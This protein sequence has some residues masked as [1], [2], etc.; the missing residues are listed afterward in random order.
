MKT[1]PET[2]AN[3]EQSARSDVRRSFFRRLGPGLLTGVADD[4]PSGI[5]TYS[6][7]GSQFGYNVLWSAIV[8]IPLMV[9]IQMASAHIGR[10]T[11]KGIL[12]EVRLQHSKRTAV[13][14]AAMIVLANVINVGADLAAMGDATS[15]LIKGPNYGYALLFAVVTLFLQIRMK[16]SAYA[17]YLKWLALALFA[18]IANIFVVHTDW[19]TALQAIVWPAITPSKE[20]AT[21]LVAVLGTTISPY[22]FVWQSALEVEEIEAREGDKPIK[23]ASSQYKRQETR[24]VA[25]TWVGMLASNVI[26]VCIM[27]TAAAAF[28]VHG[29]HNIESTSQAASAL[30][31]VAGKSSTLLFAIGLV[32]CGLLAIPSLAG[33]AAYALTGTL[34]LP[35]GMN[36][37]PQNAGTFYAVITLCMVL[38]VLLCFSPI[39]PIK[40]LYWSAVVNGVVA[41]PCMVLVMRLSSSTAIVGKMVNSRA[42]TLGGWVATALMAVSVAVMIYTNAH[43]TLGALAK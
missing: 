39:S 19:R 34:D 15:I 7:A 36:K 13:I 29:V 35:S 17:R 33:S 11:G 42:V 43:M 41:V 2:T 26:A 3:S 10:G 18:Y 23:E 14:L 27:M 1:T 37:T 5:A 40:A 32:T 20:Y 31:P 6:Q 8:T 24:I 16:Y 28:F 25:D 22:L 38:G 12:T 4:D 9:S 21:T 30:A